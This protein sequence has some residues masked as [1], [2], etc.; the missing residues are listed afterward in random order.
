VI[1][2]ILQGNVFTPS[3]DQ[4]TVSRPVLRNNPLI[5]R[6]HGNDGKCKAMS[7]RIWLR[8]KNRDHWTDRPGLESDVH[9]FL[10]VC[11]RVSRVLW[12]IMLAEVVRKS[13]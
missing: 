7:I 13:G 1:C 6:G 10:C 2:S 4:G 5:S 12:E 11:S 3:E 9:N 8:K